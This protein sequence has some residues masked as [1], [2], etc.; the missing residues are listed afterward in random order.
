MSGTK[1]KEQELRQVNVIKTGEVMATSE[2]MNVSSFKLVQT[3]ELNDK[4]TS[5]VMKKVEEVEVKIP[6]GDPTEDEVI[7]AHEEVDLKLAH[8]SYKHPRR[9]RRAAEKR[10]MQ[11]NLLEKRKK[12]DQLVADDKKDVYGDLSKL[13]MAELMFDKSG[14]TSYV[15]LIKNYAEIREI[16]IYLPKFAEIIEGKIKDADDKSLPVPDEVLKAEAKLKALYDLRAFFGIYERLL[17]DKYFAMLPHA[18]MHSLSYNE[19]RERL[20]KLYLAPKRNQE[21]ID[22]YQDL[23]RLKEL[24]LEDGESASKREEEYYNALKEEGTKKDERDPKD[25]MERMGEA[26]EAFLKI[27][28]D[29][30]SILTASDVLERKI[31]LFKTFGPD[32]K[33]F[34]NSVKK[35]KGAIK[36]L[37]EDYD[38]YTKNPPAVT[39]KKLSS[40]ILEKKPEGED[41]SEKDDGEELKG[42]KLSPAQK[43]GVRLIGSYLL[44][45]SDQDSMKFHLLETKPEQQLLVYYLV[46]NEKQD[47]AR[48]VDIYRALNNYEPDLENFKG[49]ANW[50]K[51]S[52]AFRASI[53]LNEEIKNYGL[54]SD[55]L[56]KAAGAV[57]EDKKKT[58]IKNEDKII[59]IV[60]AIA[61]RG[62]YLKMLYRNAGLHEDMPPDIA[63]D[64]VLRARMFREYREIGKLAEELKK[65]G[66]ES[67]ASYDSEKLRKDSEG[68]PSDE[69]STDYFDIANT[70]MGYVN[71]YG[72]GTI[73][74]GLG[75]LVEVS[76]FVTDTVTDSVAFSHASG[77]AGGLTAIL[78]FAGAILT[79]ASIAM[80][81]TISAAD[82][83]AQALSVSADFINASGGTM[84]S[85]TTLTGVF[86]TVSETAATTVQVLGGAA[87]A[88]AGTIQIGAS[89]VQLGRAISSKK[90]VSRARTTL[91]QKKPEELTLDEKRLKRFLNHENS[92]S[93]RG[94]T[95]AGIGILSGILAV[96]SGAL[97]AGGFLPAAAVVGLISIGLNI[98]GKILDWRWK[99][100]NRKKAVDDMLGI[101]ALMEHV[102]KEHPNAD[103]LGKKDKDKIREKLRKESL[104]MMGFSSYKECYRHIC[105]EYATLLY[106]KVFVEKPADRQMYLDAMKSLGLKM[107]ESP[108]QGDEYKPTI[109]AMVSKLMS[110]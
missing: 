97:I 71:E 18:E 66:S 82:R 8:N 89:G 63:E 15:K 53:A 6:K 26:Y 65:L 95:S 4:V 21:L 10:Q 30:D 54:I 86:T 51:I 92:E 104:A 58:D 7:N 57:E 78:G 99:A 35:P 40:I 39:E 91:D 98:T 105:T 60:Q 3:E 34:R 12:A 20:N 44:S 72:M 1:Q 67:K 62:V 74:A 103:E 46:E 110:G 77:W 73:V 83:T 59:H 48:G 29:K 24:G 50:K 43:E 17:V 84:T 13:N 102:L 81:H 88:I 19:L 22:Y 28:G 70:G 55:E 49:K 69:E 75:N 108:V 27:S 85:I 33:E 93:K 79:S 31:L 45:K 106:N 109:D 25:E 42:I 37:L 38:E 5:P 11:R 96:T 101:D 61:C 2:S 41:F 107:V 100:R 16:M 32:I 94:I 56:E 64:P 52:R 14:K 80:E 90:D 23:I 9:V 87:A 76:G 68:G 47:R 36:K